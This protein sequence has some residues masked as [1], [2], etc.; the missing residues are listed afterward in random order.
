MAAC[1]VVLLVLL[2]NYCYCVWLD[3]D[4]FY[5]YFWFFIFNFIC[6]YLE[7]HSMLFVVFG[8]RTCAS[9][10]EFVLSSFI[11]SFIYLFIPFSCFYSSERIFVAFL[12]VML[13]LFCVSGI[14]YLHFM[15]WD[16]WS[17]SF[18]QGFLILWFLVIDLLEVHLIC[19]SFY[20][21]CM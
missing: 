16:L 10:I 21:F 14:R 4:F 13:L 2:T 18:D 17:S 3:L 9:I 19:F 11:T 1:V 5:F 7:F 15:A 6:I 12:N 20:F 8:I